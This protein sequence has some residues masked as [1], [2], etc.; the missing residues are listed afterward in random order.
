M[1]R[2]RIGAPSS[3]SVRDALRMY[4]KGPKILP[5]FVVGRVVVCMSKQL[6][7]GFKRPP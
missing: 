7:F 4:E 6:H 2:S 3:S 1:H 5:R